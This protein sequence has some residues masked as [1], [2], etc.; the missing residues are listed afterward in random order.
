M[1]DAGLAGLLVTL[2]GGTFGQVI[3]ALQRALQGSVDSH[4]CDLPKVIVIGSESV[5]KSSL[6]ENLTKLRLFPS[7]D[8]LKTRCPI[9]LNLHPSVDRDGP[10]YEVSKAGH[11]ALPE[12]TDIEVALQ[13]IQAFMPRE[14]TIDAEPIQVKVTAVSSLHRCSRVIVAALVCNIPSLQCQL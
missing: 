12:T 8:G 13:R 1:T 7:G 10:I 5:G 6:L 4:L 2:R 14:G 9:A 3:D 11:R